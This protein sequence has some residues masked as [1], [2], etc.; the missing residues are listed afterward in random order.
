MLAEWGALTCKTCRGSFRRASSTSRAASPDPARGPRAASARDARGRGLCS[1]PRPAAGAAR[2]RAR[3]HTH[4][5]SARPSAVSLSSTPWM[6]S[7]CSALSL[8]PI[9]YV[10][11]VRLR[12]CLESVAP[13][14]VYGRTSTSSHPYTRWKERSRASHAATPARVCAW[15][16]RGDAQGDARVRVRP[17][18]APTRAPTHA[19][20]PARAHTHPCPPATRARARS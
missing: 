6:V 7:I 8:C 11:S 4:T 20:A 5:C 16:A 13:N 15:G 12:K 1:A 18:H 14:T 10:A 9:L 17:P 3:A 2:A 19:H